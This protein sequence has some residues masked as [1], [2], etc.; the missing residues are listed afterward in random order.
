MA[1]AEVYA[2]PVIV[3]DEFHSVPFRVQFRRSKLD[4]PPL[5]DPHDPRA[6]NRRV[7]VHVLVPVKEKPWLRPRHLAVEC[8]KTGMDGV[9][10]RLIVPQKWR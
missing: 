4:S 3:N 1:S 7:W 9:K 5:K 2:G 8:L 10:R 6:P